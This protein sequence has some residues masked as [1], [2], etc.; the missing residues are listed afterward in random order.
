MGWGFDF[1]Y[2]NGTIRVSAL[3]S[4]AGNQDYTYHIDDVDRLCDILKTAAHEAREALYSAGTDEIARHGIPL[5]KEET[6]ETKGYPGP[7]GVADREEP[8]K[9]NTPVEE[10]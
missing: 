2:G 8:A 1:R 5:P 3:S 7:Y 9:E 6:T 4:T 10:Q